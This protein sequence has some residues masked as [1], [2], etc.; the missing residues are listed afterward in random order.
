MDD[1]FSYSADLFP[2][3]ENKILWISSVLKDKALVWYQNRKETFRQKNE[4]DDWRRFW[5]AMK[6]RFRDA[7]EQEEAERKLNAYEYRNDV[8]SYLAQMR[9]HNL[10]VGLT[11][12]AW[13]QRLKQSLPSDILQRLS[14][15]P[16]K[17]EDDEDFE[18]RLLNSGRNHEDFKRE[19]ELRDRKG[20]SE[21]PSRKEDK[22]KDQDQS[23]S[24][25]SK[26]PP[27]APKAMRQKG[28]QTEKATQ[29]KRE[30]VYKEVGEA[31]KGVPASLVE[32]RRRDNTCL[33]CGMDNHRWSFCR[34]PANTN[35]E[36][37]GKVAASKRKRGT[38]DGNEQPSGSED[39]KRKTS[40]VILSGRTTA[41]SVAKSSGSGAAVAAVQTQR[42][43]E[44]SEDEEMDMD[45]ADFR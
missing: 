40:S 28:K 13:R 44:L 27:T 20:Q 2:G 6:E 16:I 37:S 24:E 9:V 34:K 45:V 1:Y 5:L 8:A 15:Y 25:K 12:V 41:H 35:S 10:K 3:D 17:P 19:K 4:V 21:N 11:G 32:K 31:T 30:T 26:Y 43:F 7:F 22:R 23:R 18:R 36:K 42:I 38:D 33:R 29:Q 14:Q 39:K